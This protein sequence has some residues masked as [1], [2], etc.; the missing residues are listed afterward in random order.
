VLFIR[1]FGGLFFVIGVCAWSPLAVS[2]T[3]LVSS[4][5]QV[6]TH[7]VVRSVEHF[8]QLVNQRTKGEL[9]VVVKAEGSAGSEADTLRAVQEGRQA[10]ARVN[11]GF[12]GDKLPA[13]ELASLPYLFRSSDHMWRVLKGEFG[14][15]LD[16]EMEQ[17][18]YI[19]L[20]YLD[21]APRDFYCMKPI[22][23]QADFEG[24]KI[25]V[26]PSKVLEDLIQN[27]GAKPVSL[28]FNKIADA[29]KAGELDCA[30]GGTVNFVAADHHKITPFLI[31]DEHTSDARGITVLEEGVG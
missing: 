24:R 3:V 23:S 28:S 15:R 30:D 4:D 2:G 21:S 1:R 20:M 17:A 18:G 29:F 31:Q 10:M 11:L 8:G 27:L 13:A 16:K 9:S 6:A 25:R 22:R 5:Q 14:Q 26:M 7:P 19:R 12:L